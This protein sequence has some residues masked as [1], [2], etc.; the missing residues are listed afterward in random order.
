MIQIDGNKLYELLVDHCDVHHSRRVPSMR[1]VRQNFGREM[2]IG[3]T[4][5][6]LVGPIVPKFSARTHP[7][8]LTLPNTHLNEL[9]R[10]FRDAGYDTSN[11]SICHRTSHVTYT[12]SDISFVLELTI[13][14]GSTPISS[15]KRGFDSF[16]FAI[17][18]NV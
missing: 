2:C 4:C 12:I 7:C 3:T 8:S 1:Y 11:T 13:E 14:R 18:R 6:T 16:R 9:L 15:Y 5:F 10:L 17:R